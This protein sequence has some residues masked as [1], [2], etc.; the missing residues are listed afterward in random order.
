M[1]RIVVRGDPIDRLFEH[2]R[3]LE[4]HLIVL[5]KHASRR[6]SR[7]ANWSGS[8]SRHTALFAPVSVLIVP[9]SRESADVA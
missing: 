5:G 2:I 1:R 4:P 8:V 9:P 6:G 7:P 3:Q